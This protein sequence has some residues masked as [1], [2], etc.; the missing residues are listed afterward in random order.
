VEL[1]I[2][3]SKDNLENTKEKSFRASKKEYG[4]E[5][6]SYLY[7]GMDFTAN[8]MLEYNESNDT[9]DLSGDVI[10]ADGENFGYM[11]IS[12]KLDLDLVLAILQ[13]YMKK[14]NKL[15]TVLEATK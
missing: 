3:I 6:S 11:N 1:T 12:V 9:I 13:A 10:R 5:E 7:D 15:K 14:F 4:E 2:N 8:G